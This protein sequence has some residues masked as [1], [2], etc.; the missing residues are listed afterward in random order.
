M[1]NVTLVIALGGNALLREGETG[2]YEEQLTH[3]G[4]TA[5]R[6]ARVVQAGFRRILVTHG[7]G[8]QVGN[9]LLQNELAAASVPP[10]PLDGCVAQSQGG[11]GYMIQQG[12]AEAFRRAGV[13]RPV[14]TVVTQVVVD[15]ADP[16]FGNPTKPVGRFYTEAEACRLMGARG[17]RMKEDAGRGWRRLVP[18]PAPLEIVEVD[19][20]RRLIESGTVVVGVGGGGI[21]VVRGPDRSLS[22][23]ECVVDKDLATALAA[24]QLGAH[25][26]VILTG[27]PKVCVDFGRPTQRALERVSVAELRSLH[28]AGH[29]AAGSMG[30]KVEAALEFLRPLPVG[31]REGREVLITEPGRVEE[32]LA[33]RDGTH[34]VA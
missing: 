12:L 27:V 21:P 33:G 19:V 20:L 16:A 26:L 2:T 6:L 34:V 9:L 10:N 3:V 29:F 17:W 28:A 31:S 14:A 22:G 11:M 30:P 23:I 13:R 1:R 5:A 32:A 4:E 8:P 15:P 18:S 7:N 24:R 25:V